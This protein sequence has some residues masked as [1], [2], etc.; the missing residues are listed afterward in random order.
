ML[1][2]SLK[3]N[4]E[5]EAFTREGVFEPAPEVARI[6]REL[7]GRI[8]RSEL[9]FDALS[10]QATLR[11]INGKNVGSFDMDCATDDGNN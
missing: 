9:E 7:A 6:L 4:L 8:E 10:W 3:L 1:Q 2:A 5:S 11:D